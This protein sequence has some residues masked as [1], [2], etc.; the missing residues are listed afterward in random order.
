MLVKVIVMAVGLGL[1]SANYLQMS[2]SSGTDCQKEVANNNVEEKFQNESLM[3]QDPDLGDTA[4]VLGFDESELSK[5][6]KK[7]VQS[8]KSFDVFVFT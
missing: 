3:L 7:E 5:S 4:E 2:Y 8:L 6:M 1:A